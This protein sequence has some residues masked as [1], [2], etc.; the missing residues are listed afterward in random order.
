MRQL[1][2]W[3]P[4]RPFHLARPPLGGKRSVA[5]RTDRNPA[6]RVIADVA[7]DVGVHEV[8]CRHSKRAERG[9][10]L[11]PVVR[12]IEPEKGADGVVLFIQRGPAECERLGLAGFGSWADA[13]LFALMAS[14]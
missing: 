7:V 3:N 5:F 14:R 9:R 10:E 6:R 8:L 11:G 1:I 12:L 13:A 4:T 2:E